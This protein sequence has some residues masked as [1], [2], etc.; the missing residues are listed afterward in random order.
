VKDITYE[1]VIFGVFTMVKIQVVFWV[2]MPFSV[3]GNQH[4][5][6][7]CC[8]YLQDEDGGSMVEVMKLLIMQSSPASPHLIPHR[9]KYPHYPVLKHPHYMFFL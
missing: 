4:F 8:L 6:G 2:V 9:S 5:G 7:P 1:A 3:V